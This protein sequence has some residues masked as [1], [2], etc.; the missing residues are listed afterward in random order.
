MKHTTLAFAIVSAFCLVSPCLADEDGGNGEGGDKAGV[1]PFTGQSSEIQSLED[2]TRIANMKAELSQARY[3]HARY[4]KQINELTGPSQTAQTQQSQANDDILAGLRDQISSLQSELQTVRRNQEQAKTPAPKKQVSRKP[5]PPKP[6]YVAVIDNNQPGV[7]GLFQYDSKTVRASA[8]QDIGPFHVE[9]ITRR[10]AVI[11][12]GQNRNTVTLGDN[13]GRIS[14]GS[15]SDVTNFGGGT[16][17]RSASAD[18]E[19]RQS[20]VRLSSG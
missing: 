16:G 7:K 5:Q 3:K 2:D 13:P 9:S 14:T 1:N 15:D 20:A 8:G 11:T 19:L 4:E 17:G 6:S 10:S 18:A 12:R